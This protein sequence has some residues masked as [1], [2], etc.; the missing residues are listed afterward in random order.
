MKKNIILLLFF[1][2]FN[3][4][5]Q[6]FQKSENYF[7]TKI[8]KNLTM[9]EIQN[10]SSV[11][12]FLQDSKNNNLKKIKVDW[13]SYENDGSV[14]EI[15]KPKL[16]NINKIIKVLISNCSCYC[17]DE[18][19]YWLITKNGLWIELPKIEEE[20]FEITQI[21]KVYSFLENEILLIE[22]KFKI[23]DYNKREMETK[24]KKVI[25]KYSWNGEFLKEL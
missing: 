3:L 2:P 24:Y 14:I 21:T 1:I 18:T 13:E 12:V 16:T 7:L 8:D 19:Y 11:D 10:V 22:E 17:N 20:D 5:C 25:K 9:E 4:I 23:I 6:E 15:N